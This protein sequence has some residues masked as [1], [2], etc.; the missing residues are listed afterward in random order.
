MDGTSKPKATPNE[1]STGRTCGAILPL[2]VAIVASFWLVPFDCLLFDGERLF[3]I[4]MAKFCL[5]FGSVV[6]WVF[7]GLH[8]STKIRQ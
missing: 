7:R 5:F 2:I 4:L 3:L 8:E 6:G 1:E